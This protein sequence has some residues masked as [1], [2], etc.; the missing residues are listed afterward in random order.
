MCRKAVYEYRDKAKKEIED[1]D[2]YH[3]GKMK[4]VKG[5]IK[6][7]KD[8]FKDINLLRNQEYANYCIFLSS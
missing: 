5:N 3:A 8:E 6:R 2:K 1:S 4:E 7:I